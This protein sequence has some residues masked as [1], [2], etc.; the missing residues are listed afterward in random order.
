MNTDINDSRIEP[1]CWADHPFIADRVKK[2]P[3]TVA[4]ILKY[5]D[6]V[7]DTTVPVMAIQKHSQ[8]LY[9]RMSDKLF[10]NQRNQLT[11]LGIVFL[12]ILLGIELVVFYV[13]LIT[14]SREDLMFIGLAW[15]GLLIMIYLNV[16]SVQYR[17]L[18]HIRTYMLEEES[19]IYRDLYRESMINY[20][21]L[22][23]AAD[24]ISSNAEQMAEEF[25]IAIGHGKALTETLEFQLSQINEVNEALVH[26]YQDL[27]RRCDVKTV[28]RHLQHCPSKFISVDYHEPINYVE[29]S[30]TIH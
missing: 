27:L 17:T 20:S 28:R 4:D 6:S 9:D 25:D 24:E 13:P 21:E 15:V 3:P 10:N 2:L 7:E 1:I 14:M 26:N 29:A 22:L 23:T 12:L 30:N 18:Q 8:H 11:R 5:D 16:V 19:R